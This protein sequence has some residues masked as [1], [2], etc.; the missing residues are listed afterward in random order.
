MTT[1]ENIASPLQPAPARAAGRVRTAVG[2]AAAAMAF[3]LMAVANLSIILALPFIGL[4]FA[5]IAPTLGDGRRVALT[6]RNAIVGLLAL[7]GLA[8]VALLPQE[9]VFLLATVGADAAMLV[10]PSPGWWPSVCRWPC[11]RL[12]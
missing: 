12:R 11:R 2:L 8:V 6:W 1:A 9:T 10:S 5:W 7:A 4:C 3:A